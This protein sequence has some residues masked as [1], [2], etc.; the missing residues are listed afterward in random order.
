MLFRSSDKYLLK[1]DGIEQYKRFKAI[2]DN[3]QIPSVL[4]CNQ[5]QKIVNDIKVIFDNIEYADGG[6]LTGILSC[7]EELQSDL[8]IVG[9]DYPLV[10]LFHINIL[11]QFSDYGFSEIAFVK[12]DR[13]NLVEPLICYLRK[14]SLIRLKEYYKN[15]GRSLNAFLQNS[16]PLKIQLEDDTFLK[17]FDTIEDY[18]SYSNY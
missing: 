2:F 14:S 5:H 9:C 10:K 1:Y 11:K 17:S 6:P 15:G 4:S 13:P 7:F 8:I 12:K 18:Q 3:A 16:N